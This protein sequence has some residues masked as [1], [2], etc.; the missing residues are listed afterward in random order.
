M[1]LKKQVR[2]LQTLLN[3]DARERQAHREDL[4]QVLKKLK[5]E[6][7][8]LLQQSLAEFD[9]EKLERLHTQINMIHAQ[10]KKGIRAL[11]SLQ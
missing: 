4:K 7:S 2:K 6:E 11:K 10:R 9:R 3:A 5:N 8:R 1:S